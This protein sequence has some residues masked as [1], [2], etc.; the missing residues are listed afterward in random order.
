MTLHDISEQERLKKQLQEQ[1]EQLDAALNN[2]S[3]GLAMFDSEQRLVVCNS[4][5]ARCTAG[6][7]ADATRH[8]RAADPRNTA[9]TN[10]LYK[11]GELRRHARQQAGAAAGGISTGWRTGA[12]FT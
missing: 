12:S 11:T 5:T 9:S 4:S 3:Q 10:G 7:G 2:M 8:D 1:N 6:A